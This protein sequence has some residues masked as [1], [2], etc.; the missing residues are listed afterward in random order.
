MGGEE[1]E[2]GGDKGAGNKVEGGTGDLGGLENGC[3]Y[4]V[5]SWKIRGVSLQSY[6]CD[7]EN[8]HTVTFGFRRNPDVARDKRSGGWEHVQLIAI[9]YHTAAGTARV[10][11][12]ET[13]G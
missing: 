5:L 4:G 12:K 11:C 13:K 8:L 3:W 9:D 1:V 10:E 6:T 2:E 7:L